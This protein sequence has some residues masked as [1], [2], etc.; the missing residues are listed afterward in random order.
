MEITES[1]FTDNNATILEAID[2]L[3]AAG[4]HILMDDFGSGSSSL[5]MLHTMKLDVL[6]TDVQ[7]MSSDAQN[8]RAISIVESIISMAHM[9]GMSVVTEGVETKVQKDNLIS[10][11][12]NYAQGYF[13]YKPMPVKSFEALISDPGNVTKGY[14]RKSDGATGQL[15][16]REMIQ[17]GLVSET[18]LDNI[19]RAA[20]ILKREEDDVSIVQTNSQFA[21][22]LGHASEDEACGCFVDRLD[23]SSRR[24]LY[25]LMDQA[26]THALGG[27][28]GV[29]RY[30]RADGDAM[31]LNMRVFLLYTLDNHRLYLTTIS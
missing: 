20:A 7:F 30:I 17:K 31:A 18:L 6:K 29:V 15:R 5:S 3:H 21:Q 10:M 25:E 14:R 23:E 11:G 8:S 28:E 26:N 12:E 24:A 1:A 4:F 9:I 13:F 27:S 22:T 16:F 2:K 19:I